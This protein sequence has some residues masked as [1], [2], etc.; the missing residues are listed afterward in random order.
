MAYTSQNQPQPL[1]NVLVPSPG[2]PVQITATL[3]TTAAGSGYI[4]G[5]P[6]D[7]V[8]CK[9]ISI[10]SSPITHTGAG[11]TG[12]IYFGVKGMVKATLA[13][14]IAV[15]TPGQSIPVTVQ[16]TVNPM[17]ANKFYV[18][19]DNANDGFYGSILTL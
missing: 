16:D 2:T 19:A 9:M 7:D 12:S 13:G 11:N 14:V 17:D 5:S 18:D 3:Q 10:I 8:P 4:V 6:T 1:G 15:L